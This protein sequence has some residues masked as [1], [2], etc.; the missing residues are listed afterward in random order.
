MK[1]AEESL[2]DSGEYFG[3]TADAFARKVAPFGQ[4]DELIQECV[5]LSAEFRD[6]KVKLKEPRNGWKDRAVVLSYGNL[7]AEKLDNKYAKS[8]QKQTFDLENIQL[9]W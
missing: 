8:T 6:G 1:E 2:V 4:T 5:N 3:L 7:I 9:V